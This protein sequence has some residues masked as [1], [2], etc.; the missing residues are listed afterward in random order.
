MARKELKKEKTDVED[1]TSL[2][3]TLAS[4]FILGIFIAGMWVGVYFVF[5]NRF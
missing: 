5:L 1:N 4:V 3:G 2:K